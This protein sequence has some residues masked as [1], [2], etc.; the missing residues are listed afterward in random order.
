M[1]TENTASAAKAASGA[2]EVSGELMVQAQ[3]WE[4]SSAEFTESVTFSER[5]KVTGKTVFYYPSSDD[6][7]W[8]VGRRYGVEREK[9]REANSIES[10][11]LPAV[12]KIPL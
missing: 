12:C 8:T 4:K 3:L 11:T 9:I 7:L 10:D 5:D 6:T 1:K 2:L